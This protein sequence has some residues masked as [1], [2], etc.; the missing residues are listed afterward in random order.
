V[1][2]AGVNG[3]N[4]IDGGARWGAV[5]RGNQGDVLRLQLGIFKV[6]SWAVG[7]LEANGFGGG[8]VGLRRCGKRAMTGGA[9]LSA[10]CG[11]GGRFPAMEVETERGTGAPRGPAGSGEEG[12]S[13]GRSGPAWQAGLIP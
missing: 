13:A 6:Q 1:V 12:G 5:M 2:T 7:Q 3:F 8:A 10:R 11:E 9:H 4:T